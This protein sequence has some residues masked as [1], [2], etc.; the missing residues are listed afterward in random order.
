MDVGQRVVG[1][2]VEAKRVRP[3]RRVVAEQAEPGVA[4]VYLAVDRGSGKQHQ[5]A[6]VEMLARQRR[7]G[8]VGQRRLL[9]GEMAADASVGQ[10]DHALGA[11]ALA[12]VHDGAY[13]DVRSGQ[14]RSAWIA[15][16]CAVEPH[17][18]ADLGVAQAYFAAADQALLSE[19]VVADREPC[20][21]Q[22]TFRAFKPGGVQ[23]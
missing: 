10:L 2:P 1:Q 17:G 11:E 7:T 18:A 12:A 23:E 22:G 14:C 3:R 16:M 13:H 4:Q 15:Q 8:R 5:L 20:C 9:E 19:D 6:C 21:V